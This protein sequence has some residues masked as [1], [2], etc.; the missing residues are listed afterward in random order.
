M[1]QNSNFNNGDIISFKLTNGEE[2]LAK[3]VNSDM[4]TYAISKPITIMAQQQGLQFVQGF[5]T[6]N[7]D[8]NITLNKSAVIMTA[9]PVDEVVKSYT[10]ATTGIALAKG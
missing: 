6:A 9:T 5:F 1:L 4:S 2:I 3:L 10:E 7:Q 8:K